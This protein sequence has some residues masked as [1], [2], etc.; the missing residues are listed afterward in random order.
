MNDLNQS[1]ESGMW[2]V[3]FASDV[4]RVMTLDQLDAAF[5]AG[6][7]G[8]ETLVR[9]DGVSAWSKLAEIAGIEPDQTPSAASYAVES[10]AVG[11][12]SIRPVVSELSDVDPSVDDAPVEL[13]SRKRGPVLLAVAALMLL[14]G[15]G[16]GATKLSVLPG[17]SSTP[18]SAAQ[19]AAVSPIVS[20]PSN[21]TAAISDAHLG[22]QTVPKDSKLTDAQKKLVLD[23]DKK[24]A[25]A[26]DE[27]KAR[28]PQKTK[29][30]APSGPVFHTGGNVHDPL[31]SSISAP[32]R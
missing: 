20:L 17:A 12:Q 13:R 19:P 1:N 26:R 22:E 23:A 21:L 3:Q 10:S 11:P 5:Q 8:E 9:Q 28:T 14:G 18:A 27:K 25:Q 31:N 30:R 29:K 16:F 2:Y 32:A 7:I 15:V 6:S 24:R 4:V